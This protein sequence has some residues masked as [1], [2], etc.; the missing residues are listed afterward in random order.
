MTQRIQVQTPVLA[1]AAGVIGSLADRAGDA[2]ADAAA[3]E[4]SAA[5]FGGEPAGA[6]FEHACL[7]GMR[8]VAE[9]QST[10]HQLSTNVGMAAL[11]YLNTDLGVIP[12]SALQRV[13]RF[14]P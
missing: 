13:S 12:I 11:G 14:K 9:L 2:H 4:A 5:A 7:D 10:I 8:A 6:A 1:A 3:A